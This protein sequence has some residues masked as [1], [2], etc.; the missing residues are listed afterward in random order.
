MKTGF[1]L[2]S[3]LLYSLVVAFPSLTA[4]EAPRHPNLLLDRGEIEEIKEKIRK[5]PWA[6]RL[7]EAV[8]E[9]AR[10]P[11]RN[12]R[13]AALAYVLTGERAHADRVREQL[14]NDARYSLDRYQKLDLKLEPEYGAWSPWG[15]YAW[16]YDLTHDTF[17]EGEREVV[18]RWLRTG[19]RNV[20][21]G[22]RLWTTTPN[23]VFGKHFNVGLVG[24][25]L[26]DEELIEWAL[27]D[28]GAHGPQRGGFYQVLDTMINDG[29]FW[30]ESPI[31][32]L[33]YDVHGMLALAEAA[34]HHGDP[35]L[36]A[37]VSPR[38][39][40]S[41][42]TIVDGYIR[43]G[44]P[45]EKTGVGAGAIRMA[46]YGDGS[47][48]YTPG[49][50]LR[51]TYL[52]PGEHFPG[53]LE[54]AYKRYR[55]PGHAWLLSLGPERDA[56]LDYGRAVWGP[57]ALT[58]GEPL[59]ER[60][61]PPPAP[62]GV[63]PGQGFALL[64]SDDSPAYWTSGAMAALVML[65]K[66]IGH[67][68]RDFYSLTLHG[69][70]RL[71]YPDLNV[72]QYE[73]TY[74]NWTREGIAHSTLLVDR[75]SP[76]GGPFTTREDFHSDLKFLRISG[77]A[78]ANVEQ[79]RTLLLTKEYLAD[80]FHARDPGGEQR[81][82]DWVLHGLGRLF[83]G[84]PAAYRRTDD[85]VPYYWW[86]DDERSRDVA[87]TW[88]A[89][90]IQSSAGI[91]RGLPFGEE[92]FQG[93]VGVRMTM[94]GAVGTRVYCGDGPLVDGPPHGRIDG[95]PEGASPMVL[96]RR[97][98]AS[99]TFAALHEPYGERP[100]GIRLRQ[101][102]QADG[103]LVMAARGGDFTDYLAVALAP[104]ERAAAGAGD[105]AF[106]F[107][108]F[109]YLRLQPGSARLRGGWKWLRVSAEGL[110]DAA[111]AGALGVGLRREGKFLVLGETPG[112]VPPVSGGRASSG[113]E[114]SPETDASLHSWFEPAEAHLRSTEGDERS[115]KLR[116]RC[117]GDGRVV[118]ALR[119]L[120]PPGVRVAPDRIEIRPLAGGEETEAAF[121]L[122]VEAG[123]RRELGRIRWIP[124]GELR[125]AEL[126]LPVSVGV[127]IEH[128]R[129][130]PLA[131]R[132]VVRAPGYTF[133]VD[134]YSG[135]SYFLLDAEGRRRHGRIH[136]TNFINGF[137][138]VM[139]DGKWCFQYRHPCGFVWA[140]AGGLTVGCA[141]NYDDHDVRLGYTFEEDRISIALVPPTR[142]GVDHTVW[143]GNFDHDLGEP[144]RPRP[145][146]GGEEAAARFFFPHP[147]HSQGVV[148]ELPSG[149]ELQSTG[150]A[151]RFP[152][153]AGQGVTLRF[154]SEAAAA[155]P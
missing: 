52:V 38:S 5:E 91:T 32:A 17:P 61:L 28:P 144:R 51:E 111:V 64:R 92:W 140:Q 85:L 107:V 135:V 136:N 113:P 95:N 132:Y 54:I 94:L 82:F 9:K 147:V 115:V 47:T 154:A 116:M 137:P 57:V 29:L 73:P 97:R 104:G 123:A 36:Y 31:Y 58:H 93:R 87:A 75:R 124:E 134:E 80:V 59:P 14:G 108:D 35:D 56:Q 42:R 88:R 70:G 100:M 39:G 109:G 139:R 127:V 143:L 141:G 96:A 114:G 83:P 98:G 103:A 48:S 55:D 106:R 102:A 71:L 120:A 24:Y 128:D 67:G 118:G 50:A 44:Y 110:D 43:L 46:T 152:L 68:H 19:A 63:Y 62:S 25:C 40:A 8:V 72:I 30:G 1:L 112:D 150:A 60:P 79:A 76:Q 34:R 89:D 145:R 153:R 101:V 138:G 7:L 133:A 27:N 33:H 86:I 53:V 129:R 121:V 37:H 99:A 146:P 74:L 148:I 20:I 16:A 130:L 119:A 126:S 122:R 2:P 65:G 105:E 41:I 142:P 49:G 21:E 69:K 4:G 3:L 12:V 11:A 13:E 125:S 6:A 131:A 155:E 77:S 117:V 81:T 26:G 18:E 10:D 90:W 66:P 15:T 84:N 45:L 151:V 22:E 78:F 23:L 149:T